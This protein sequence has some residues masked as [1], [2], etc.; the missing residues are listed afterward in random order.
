MSQKSRQIG[1]VLLVLGIL[2]YM[3]WNYQNRHGEK[4]L[5]SR[6]T[7]YWESIRIN[8][9]A[10]AYSLE[11]E[12]EAGLLQPHEVAI[13]QDWGRR[14]VGFE[15]GEITYI[16]NHAEIEVTREI[17][18]PDSSQTKTYP[19]LKD[20]WTFMSGRWFHGEPELGNSPMRKKPEEPQRTIY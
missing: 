7:L 18:L 2:G 17:T 20:V 4:A 8:D 15:F 13:Y 11:A 1:M 6:A 5:L 3:A 12:A 16:Q 19:G 10:T 9:L 14:L